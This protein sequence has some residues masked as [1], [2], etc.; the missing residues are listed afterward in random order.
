MEI[1][2]IFFGKD[3]ELVDLGGGLRRKVVANNENLMVVEVYFNTGTVAGVHDHPHEQCTYIVSGEFEFEI[4]GKK[5]ILKAGDSAYK[6]GSL[7][8]GA[9][10]L[11][12]GMLIDVFTPCR[13]DFL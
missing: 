7:P 10:C 4:G 6:Q 5:T 9:V 11:K 3:Q 13:K 1:K 2:N 8:H 12:E